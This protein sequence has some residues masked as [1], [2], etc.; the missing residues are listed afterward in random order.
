MGATD[1]HIT[2]KPKNDTLNYWMKKITLLE[3]KTILKQK[4]DLLM[5]F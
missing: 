1:L 3:S 4:I 5:Q 2:N